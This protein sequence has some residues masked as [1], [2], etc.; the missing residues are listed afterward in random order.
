MPGLVPVADGLYPQ[1]D[2][3]FLPPTIVAWAGYVGKPEINAWTAPQ[4][5]ALE[6][7]GRLWLPIWTPGDGVD[8]TRAD[9]QADAASMLAGLR[10][11]GIDDGRW[12]WLDIERSREINDVAQC[13]DA[14]GYWCDIM[15]AS[16]WPRPGWYGPWGSSAQWQ[17]NWTGIPPTS[18]PPGVLGQQY[19]HDLAGGR[20]DISRFDPAVLER[21]TMT[22]GQVTAAVWDVTVDTGVQGAEP[23]I[24]GHRLANIDERV[25]AIEGAVA[26]LHADIAALSG[27]VSKIVTAQGPG[28]YH[29]SASITLTPG[30]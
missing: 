27:Q 23:G 4:V 18:L 30:A 6:A 2:Y 13:E 21:G 11:L 3:S 16:G 26:Q 17:P 10:A 9:A 29:G 7:T 20:Y 12:V 5:A 1:P 14:A 22:P 19:D 25:L 8:Y 15:R 28:S 24:A